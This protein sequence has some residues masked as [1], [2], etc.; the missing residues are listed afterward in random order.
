MSRTRGSA[1]LGGAGFHFELA[2]E[3]RPLV[4]LHAG[5]CDARMWDGQFDAL[6]AARRVLRY[7]RRGFGRTTQGAEAFSHVED[8]AALM[9]HFRL[10]RAALV[11]CS[12]GARVA[13]DFALKYAGAVE[14]LVL[15]A[16]A[17]SGYGYGA[18]P[19]SEFEEIGRAA[20]AGDVELVNELELRVWVDGPR[21]APH[22]V[23]GG[24]RE[25]V[26]EM[27]L[28]ALTSSAGEELPSG[29]EAAGRLGEVGVP[30]L[31]VVGDL[32]TP[33]TLEAA[34]V[35]AKGIRGARLEVIEGTAHLPNMERP[36]EFNRVVLEFL[37]DSGGGT[38]D[39]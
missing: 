3:G 34:G 2:G 16:P 9:N 35:L 14:A 30:T 32:D 28:A 1:A 15:V 38:E 23:D 5:I 21:R 33:R 13:L 27:N 22:E 4:L 10:G 25:L 26:R 37:K 6:A 20:E 19:P 12:Q 18:A 36:R 11:G 31:V 8:L 39:R 7:D 17:V 24:V 29:V